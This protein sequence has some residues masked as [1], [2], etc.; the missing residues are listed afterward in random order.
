MALWQNQRVG[1]EGTFC[2]VP[3]CFCVF[4]NMK[5]TLNCLVVLWFIHNKWVHSTP[6]LT[7]F[8]VAW[9]LV[10]CHVERVLHQSG[11]PSVNMP[12]E[13]CSHNLLFRNQ[14]QDIG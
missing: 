8:L 13:F 7:W 12:Y 10:A 9:F 4:S 2:H 3:K 11:N 1:R 5:F 14:G 6:T